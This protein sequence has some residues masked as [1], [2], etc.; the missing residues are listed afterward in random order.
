MHDGVAKQLTGRTAQELHADAEFRMGQLFLYLQKC[1]SASVYCGNGSPAGP[2]MKQLAALTR[3]QIEQRVCELLRCPPSRMAHLRRY[4]KV[5]Y[6]EIMTFWQLLI[7]R[8]EL[9]PF[10]RN[11]AMDDGDIVLSGGPLLHFG[12]G[13]PA[14]EMRI[15]AFA[16]FG[17]RYDT[18]YQVLRPCCSSALSCRDSR[19]PRSLLTPFIT[20][21]MKFMLLLLA[22]EWARFLEEAFWMHK[23][24]GSPASHYNASQPQVAEVVDDF[25]EAAEKAPEPTS[26]A[27]IAPWAKRVFN[28]YMREF[29]MQKHFNKDTGKLKDE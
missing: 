11:V 7:P 8:E 4:D 1:T 6:R 2:T 26:A 3:D 9:K 22:Y 20:Q 13:S 29:Q 12:T 19:A 16:T 24:G 15:L 27:F 14:G 23:R 17:E 10:L 18:D 5:A 25:I 28:A 21:V